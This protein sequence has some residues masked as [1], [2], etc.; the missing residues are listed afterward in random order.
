MLTFLNSL[1]HSLILLVSYISNQ[2]SFPKPLSRAEEE[3]YLRRMAEGDED[4]KNNLRLVAHVAKKYSAAVHCGSDSEDLLSIGTI[5]LIKG[6]SSFDP[7]KGTRLATYAARCVENEIL[8]MFR[9]R[10]KSRNDVSLSDPIGTD[11]E[12]NAIMLMDVIEND[13][14]DIFDKIEMK[15]SVRTLYSN[16]SS[17]LTPRERK[18]IVLRY[19]LIDGKCRTQREIAAMLGISRSYISRIEKKAVSKLGEGIKD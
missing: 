7:S 5:G 4:A 1:I 3:E 15:G 6:I 8:M 18:I 9:S 12:G 13:D 2:A 14:S 19:G 10:K 11:K 16:L 17:K